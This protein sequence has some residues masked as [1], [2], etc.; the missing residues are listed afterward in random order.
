MGPKVRKRK[1][2]QW[3]ANG[4]SHS[5]LMLHGTSIEAIIALIEEGALPPPKSQDF[6]FAANTTNFQRSSHAIGGIGVGNKRVVLREARFY[7]KYSAWE[8]YLA[9]WCVGL[10]PTNMS[11]TRDF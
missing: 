4:I 7:A 5:P 9:G 11:E 6:Y 8:H 3:L 2:A 1:V 10:A